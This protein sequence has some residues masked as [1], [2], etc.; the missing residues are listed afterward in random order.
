MTQAN[1]G[2]EGKVKLALV[3]LIVAAVFI[4]GIYAVDAASKTT[5][6][7]T[8]SLE[9]NPPTSS[10]VTISWILNA[11][12]R[13]TAAEVAWTPDADASYT[14]V[15]AVGASAG[16]LSIEDSGTIRRTDRV[17][18]LPGANVE[19]IDSANLAIVQTVQSPKGSPVTLA[20]T[21]NSGGQVTAAEVTWL[22]DANADYTLEV[23]VGSGTGLLFIAG[24]GTTT[25]T[26]RVPIS[27]FI[28]AETAD[29]ASLCINR[30]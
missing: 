12:G 26:D 25:R 11:G 29:S 7:C 19:A 1:K 17:P 5:T 3:G 20:W 28:G 4:V 16:Q 18:I 23:T 22:P 15:I 6:G 14:L 8:G 21:V 27:P 10:P 9:V 2:V 24:S 13:I 30:A